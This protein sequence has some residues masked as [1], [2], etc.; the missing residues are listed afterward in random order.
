MSSLN[1]FEHNLE[2]VLVLKPDSALHHALEYNSYTCPEDILMQ[3]DNTI[4]DLKYLNE[5]K[6]LVPLQK[7]YVCLLRNFRQF[8]YQNIQ[9]MVTIK[10]DDWK[11]FTKE[12]F[13][14]FRRAKMN[15]SS[16]FKVSPFSIPTKPVPSSVW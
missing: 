9:G 11:A 8:A 14:A 12:Q 15:T 5:E 16:S 1:A 3:S 6:R 13:N 10:D 4:N 2:I 7:G